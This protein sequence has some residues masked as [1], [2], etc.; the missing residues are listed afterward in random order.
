[1]KSI[2]P[3]I[4]L[5]TCNPQF[6]IWS[7]CDNLYDD[8]PRHWTGM[9]HPLTGCVTVDGVEKIFMGKKRHNPYFN[10]ISFSHMPTPQIINQ[11]DLKVTP[12]KTIYTFRDDKIELEVTFFTPLLLDDL[13]LLS[14]PVSY[15]SYKIKAID[16]KNHD[17]KVYI[18]ASALLAVNMPDEMV[19][20]GYED[21][22]V[23]ASSGEDD[24]LKDA[25]DNKRISWG[26]FCLASPYGK[27]G[28]T[29]EGEKNFG[30]KSFDGIAPLKPI[31][32]DLIGQTVKVSDVFPVLYNFSEYE[33]TSLAEGFVAFA[34]DDIYS[35][36]YFGKKVKGYWTKDGDSFK[37]MFKNAVENYES[38]LK[39]VN[40]FDQRLLDEANKVSPDYA[41]IISIAY[42]Q[43]IAAHTLC[44]DGNE[45]IFI[46]KECFS[47][48]CAATVDVTYPSIPLFLI[49][50]PDLAE[51]ML[52]PIFKLIENGKWPFDF[53]PHDAGCYPIV[54]GQ[55]YGLKDGELLLDMQMPIEECGNMI[56][57]V[58]SI[59]K[60]RKN[61]SLA[62]K[63]FDLIKQWADYL[64]KYGFDPENQLCTDD[65]AGHLAHNSNLSVKA[66]MG[67]GAF[68]MLLKMM[69]KEDSYTQIAKEYAKKW[70]E[71]TFEKDHYR[72]SFDKEDSWS[73]KYNLVWDKLFNLDIFDKDV[74]E[75]EIKYYKTK[76]EKYGLPLDCRRLY[77]K[78]D[79]QMWSTILC[80]DKEYTDKIVSAMLNMLS[81][82][83][84]K[85]PFC[86]WYYTNNAA[87]SSFQN[88]SVQGGL[89]INMLKF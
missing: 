84:D 77:T 15:L 22:F 34:Y 25:G 60:K 49:Y 18:D 43:A 83:N 20:L 46:S 64:V 1:M 53:A 28:I 66:I 78:S 14:R 23:Y 74:F 69:G 33:K 72:L 67:I 40:E 8:V 65:F 44:Y 86:D 4:P 71:I 24:M 76:I 79:W 3:A 36:E 26:R 31:I 39:K 59:C 21:N 29:K 35:V 80:D 16:N 45:G 81:D 55:V 50:N 57:C 56:L 85:V 41:K 63:H 73:I 38:I 13:M 82:T 27:L 48:G 19:T 70:K 9:Q 32:N 10:Q 88:R 37:N 87:K 6:S 51:F 17:I 75:T 7:M 2:Y 47:N 54:N 89:F 68:G 30:I 11:V 52:N 12:L 61:P 42:R 62:Q 5:I 58:A